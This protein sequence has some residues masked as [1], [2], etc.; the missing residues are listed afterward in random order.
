[1]RG[2]TPDVELGR[3]LRE[4]VEALGDYLAPHES[5]SHPGGG[6]DPDAAARLIRLRAAYDRLAGGK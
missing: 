2:I 5:V 4:V 6:G 3:A 1:M